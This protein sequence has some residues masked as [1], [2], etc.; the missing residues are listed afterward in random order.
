MPSKKKSTK[1]RKRTTPAPQ[2]I[3]RAIE[4]LSSGMR[5][6]QV[7]DALRD[8]FGI[9]TRQ[10]DTDIAR[11]YELLAKEEAEERPRRKTKMRAYLWNVCRKAEAAGDW[12][13]VVSA[14]K[15]LAKIDGL[16]A[17]TEVHVGGLAEELGQLT[18]TQRAQR[19]R[20]LTGALPG[21][22]PN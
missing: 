21:E 15:L 14:C 5:Y 19:I 18:P 17:P 2:R 8:Q 7:R 4:L 20:E 11:S 13:A 10:A 3:D 22:A 12:K 16:E 1:A 9:T 6:T